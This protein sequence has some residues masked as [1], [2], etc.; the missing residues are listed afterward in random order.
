MNLFGLKIIEHNH[1]P[2]FRTEVYRGCGG[3]KFRWNIRKERQVPDPKI[4]IFSGMNVAF[5]SPRTSAM[6]KGLTI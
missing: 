1:L 3:Y 6:I 2:E 5:M 4:Y